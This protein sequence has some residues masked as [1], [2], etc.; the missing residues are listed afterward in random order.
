MFKKFTEIW[1]A[2]HELDVHIEENKK[3]TT[4]KIEDANGANNR[5]LNLLDVCVIQ[6]NN[7]SKH[8]KVKFL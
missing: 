7:R 2:S 6:H 3:L 8:H 1:N 4:Q 5:I